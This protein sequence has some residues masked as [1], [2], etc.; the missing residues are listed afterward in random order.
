[1][2]PETTLE[3]LYRELDNSMLQNENSYN[4]EIIESLSGKEENKYLTTQDYKMPDDEVNTQVNSNNSPFLS[5]PFKIQQTND[6]KLDVRNDIEKFSI[7][8]ANIESL[9][10]G[11]YFNSSQTCTK[12]MSP[13][14]VK[15][16]NILAE[17]GSESDVKS[18]T[19]KSRETEDGIERLDTV[20]LERMRKH[21][22]LPKS[23]SLGSTIPLLTP[24]M[25]EN[26]FNPSSDQLS[27]TGIYKN[28]DI[29]S[30][31]EILHSPSR[32]PI[33]HNTSL[34]QRVSN[35]SLNKPR[36]QIELDKSKDRIYEQFTK[37]PNID[38]PT[39]R[40]SSGSS[41]NDDKLELSITQIK[42]EF[43]LLTDP[44][45]YDNRQGHGSFHDGTGIMS[46]EII[47]NFGKL[48]KNR[49]IS[50]ATSIGDYQSAKENQT[51]S[52]LVPETEESIAE[53]NISTGNN[54][55][56]AISSNTDNLKLKS[57]MNSEMTS[58]DSLSSNSSYLGSK[59]SQ[60]SEP[61]EC[62]E[63]IE[64]S[65]NKNSDNHDKDL[66]ETVLQS[67]TSITNDTKT[68]QENSKVCGSQDDFSIHRIQPNNILLKS[69]EINNVDESSNNL[70]IERKI[71]D[72]KSSTNKS[73]SYSVRKCSG[74]I[75]ID[76]KSQKEEEGEKSSSTLKLD[77]DTE[78][79]VANVAGTKEFHNNERVIH[80][81][82]LD[83][84]IPSIPKEPALES[85]FI[86]DILNPEEEPLDTTDKEVL[87]KPDNYLAIWH[88]QEKREPALDIKV[89]N[90]LPTVNLWRNEQKANLKVENINYSFKPKL[91]H[92]TIINSVEKTK[93]ENDMT[94]SL[95]QEFEI[96][97]K[98]LVAESPSRSPSIVHHPIKIWPKSIFNT[99]LEELQHSK[100]VS[101]TE[102][103]GE[104]LSPETLKTPGNLASINIADSIKSFHVDE[105]S[106]NVS[107]CPTT[108]AKESSYSNSTFNKVTGHVS[109]PF[110]VIPTERRKLKPNNIDKSSEKTINLKQLP[111]QLLKTQTETVS[112][113]QPANEKISKADSETGFLFIKLDNVSIYLNNIKQ[114]DALFSIEID[115]GINVTKTEWK[116]SS[117]DKC[118]ILDNQLCIPIFK[119]KEEKLYLTL[120][121]KFRRPQKQLVEVVEKVRV[122][123]SFGGLGKSKYIYKKKFAER[124]VM[125]DEWDYLFAQDGSFARVEFVID[126]DFLEAHKKYKQLSD[127]KNMLN[128]WAKV[129]PNKDSK[130]KTLPEEL[131]RREP[132]VVASLKYKAY[133]T[134]KTNPL[135]QFP[136][137]LQDAISMAEKF[138]K[139]QE[140]TKEGYLV[141]DGGDLN[142]LIEKRYFKLHGTNLTGFNEST[143]KPKITI[144]LL[145]VKEIISTMD[146]ENNNGKS[147]RNFTNLFL[148]GEC[149]ILVFKNNETISFN[150]QLSGKETREWYS[151]LKEII[152]MNVTHQPWIKRLAD[153]L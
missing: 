27:P 96:A 100:D 26:H 12:Q 94:T 109:S 14:S 40:Y 45:K 62:E 70:N 113:Y 104:E 65:L 67:E 134:E 3:L 69:V 115:N 146:E 55:F 112:H 34:Q 15:L 130:Q 110:K 93:T 147:Y 7:R 59:F 18:E 144:N 153:E 92:N 145:N 111:D 43:N 122:G 86:D 48:Y 28:G 39:T 129:I 29:E 2:E 74:S 9:S 77:T 53:L 101:I 121:C 88:L 52:Q 133:Y 128:Q 6:S 35:I 37:K 108:P 97:L 105:E 44:V 16:I 72:Q 148:F 98:N 85:K 22:S 58:S 61:N 23:F 82:Q 8:N 79:V 32:I 64:Q 33:I 17:Q 140:I 118:L 51:K 11:T 68:S 81:K 136:K 71:D 149:F 75:D 20:V 95:S 125:Y 31:P 41:Y 127:T 19:C 124:E 142:G 30:S 150:C 50:I 49:M 13:N 63:Y 73:L 135:E 66:E 102:V 47:S 151:C 60:I 46:G 116:S 10:G 91:V 87:M 89:K 114:H 137:T 138:K 117:D 38:V 126:N 132:F 36:E 83:I 103:F 139:Q 76:E 152:E 141:Q 123:K 5:S 99:D 131:S 24:D 54:F 84:R 80:E 25:D 120:K 56:N 107:V 119:G 57:T 42:D 106:A 4:E 90:D 1:M 78:N 21:A 143:M